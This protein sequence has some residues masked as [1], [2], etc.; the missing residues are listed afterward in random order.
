MRKTLITILVA[1]ASINANADFLDE[2]KKM[3]D[4]QDWN[5]ALELLAKEAKSNPKTAATGQFLYLSGIC[6]YESGN[7]PKAKE[8]LEKA[9]EKK[10]PAANLY[11]GRLAFLDYDLER[12]TELYDLYREHVEKS[13]GKINPIIEEFET[14]LSNAENAISRV[15]NIEIL[16]SL[17]VPADSFLKS[18][19]LPTSAG[20]LID[21]E[22]IPFTDE[23]EGA[24]AAYTTESGD[25]MMWGASDSTGHI[26][27]MESLRLTDGEWQKPVSAPAIL[28]DGG[29]A[30][31]P[32]MMPDGTTLYYASDGNGSIG[33]YDIFVVTRDPQTGEYLQPQNV[34]MP[35]NSPY[36]DYMLA[37]DEEN[38][39]GWWATDRNL[40]GD[41]ITIYVYKT[42]DL[43]KNY[44]PDLEDIADKAKITDFKSTRSDKTAQEYFD[45]IGSLR[46]DPESNREPITEFM[47][48]IG[49]GKYLTNMNQVPAAAQGPLKSY[50]LAKESLE[51]DEIHL[52]ALRRRYADKHADNVKQ[53]IAQFEKEIEQKRSEVAGL[54]SEL[55]KTLRK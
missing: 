38:G 24:I 20:R 5:A 41:K 9:I 47:L 27:I 50:L 51:K 13:K 11:L 52:S 22:E 35:F 45:I 8:L 29:D 17:A 6:Q 23:R 33:G 10:Y 30:D 54:R 7:Y 3:M 12:A 44:D 46:N 15:E 48:P 28:R 34:G 40:L 32:F 49:E 43:R 1:L 18:Y 25:F 37:I 14:Q 26:N 19:L 55:Y 21:P 42:N 36:D 16:D 4:A 2:A 31:Y 53:Q 39:I